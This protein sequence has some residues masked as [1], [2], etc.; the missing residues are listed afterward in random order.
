[1][2]DYSDKFLAGV[3]K[4]LGIAG[5]DAQIETVTAGVIDPNDPLADITDTPVLHDC[6]VFVDV[7]RTQ[8]INGTLVTIGDG[9]LYVDLLSTDFVPE[10]GNHLILPDGRRQVLSAVQA[11]AI[12]NVQV[13]AI[14]V[15]TG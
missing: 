15:V 5:F 3:Q 13:V 10:N 1:M 2:S 8:Y 14:A 12:N 6:R 4:L 9:T 7:P 11:P